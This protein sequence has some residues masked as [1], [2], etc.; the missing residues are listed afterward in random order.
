MKASVRQIIGCP[1]CKEGLA[2][3]AKG[4]SCPICGRFYEIIGAV[5][6]SLT[7]ERQKALSASLSTEEGLRMKK[8]YGSAGAFLSRLSPAVHYTVNCWKQVCEQKKKPYVLSVGGGPK[9]EHP[10]LINLN[11]GNFPNVDIVGDAHELPIKSKVLDG[12]VCC[13]VL[14]HVERP[15]DVVREFQRVLGHGGY[16]YVETPFLQPLHAYPHDYFRFTIE[17]LRSLLTN[18]QELESGVIIGP[19]T[20]LT[21]LI[22]KYMELIV[23]GRLFKKMIKVTFGAIA[24]PLNRLDLLLRRK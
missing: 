7:E 17:G 13:A 15:W 1:V 21:V 22:R 8:E 11:I 10:I 3:V 5:P 18:F 23:P 24:F 16:L 9:R 2:D 6:I 12:I 19:T 4:L 14:G 20:S